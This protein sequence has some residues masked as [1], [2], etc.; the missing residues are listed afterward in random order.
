VRD[1]IVSHY[2]ES[3]EESPFP[4]QY[5]GIMGTKEMAQLVK[6]PAVCPPGP[7]FGTMG[8]Q[9]MK[10]WAYVVCNPK[11]G[12]RCERQRGFSI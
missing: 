12:Q 7:E 6:V 9:H 8:E 3:L 10:S 5:C 4:F 1:A 2:L 11:F